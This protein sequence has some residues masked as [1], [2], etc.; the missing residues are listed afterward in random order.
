MKEL[1]ARLSVKSRFFVALICLVL[2]RCGPDPDQISDLEPTKQEQRC[3][4]LLSR[5]HAVS[6]TLHKGT[7][8]Y[9][10]PNIQNNQVEI[11]IDDDTEAGVFMNSDKRDA[12]LDICRRYSPVRDFPYEVKY[13]IV[14]CVHSK[15]C[16]EW[17][18]YTIN[19]DSLSYRNYVN[20][21]CMK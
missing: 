12:I 18:R 6:I 10:E 14:T 11:R 13:L 3:L 7:L 4:K 2:V 17:Y 5:K 8:E 20:S 1:L 9:G 19:L 15:S 21:D 16:T